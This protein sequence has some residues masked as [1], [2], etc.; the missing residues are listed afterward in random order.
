MTFSIEE[1]A[2]VSEGTFR[3]GAHQIKGLETGMGTAQPDWGQGAA[4]PSQ[5]EGR[6]GEEA[7]DDALGAS[8]WGALSIK[9][10]R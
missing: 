5:D 9:L 6:A 7:L 8:S 2:R 1:W 4:W 3:V 10:R